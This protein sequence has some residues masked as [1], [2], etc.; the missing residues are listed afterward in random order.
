MR[1]KVQRDRARELMQQAGLRNHQGSCGLAELEKLQ[2]V[3]APA[4]QI[5]IFSKDHCNTIIFKGPD[6][7]K[8]LA[9]YYYNNHYD[10]ITSLP[11]FFD[12]SYYCHHCDKAYLHKDHTCSRTCKFCFG[13]IHQ[14]PNQWIKCNNCSRYYLYLK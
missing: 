3:L 14:G 5:K 7:P 4:Y 13:D 2:G 12:Q 11:A 1:S 9:I 10:V 6:A 8:I